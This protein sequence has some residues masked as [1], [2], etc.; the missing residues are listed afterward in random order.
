MEEVGQVLD[1]HQEDCELPL[2]EQE[3]ILEEVNTVTPLRPPNK[4]VDSSMDWVDNHTSE[5]SAHEGKSFACH[6][7]RSYQFEE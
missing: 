2:W 7:F 4:G 6:I 5:M 3:M 1:V